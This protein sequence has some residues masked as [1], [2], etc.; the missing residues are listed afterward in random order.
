[1]AANLFEE[2]IRGACISE[3][4]QYRYYLYRIW[5]SSKPLVMWIMLNPSTADAKVDDPTIRRC[6]NFSKSWGYGGLYVV[7]LFAYR[8][9]NPLELTNTKDPI[10]PLNKGIIDNTFHHVIEDGGKVICA[11]GNANLVDKLLANHPA[12]KPLEGIC[13]L[14]FLEMSNSGHPKHPLYLKGSLLPKPFIHPRHHI[15]KRQEV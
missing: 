14:Y 3:D 13:K 11:W 10:G 6:I 1:M 9:T 5:D 8:A 2:D 12:Y 4:K 15:F 7:N